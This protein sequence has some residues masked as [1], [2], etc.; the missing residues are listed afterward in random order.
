[1]RV[2][3]LD[4]RRTKT[5]NGNQPSS[6]CRR[7]CFS[8]PLSD[9]RLKFWMADTDSVTLRDAAIRLAGAERLRRDVCRLASDDV[10]FRGFRARMAPVPL[11]DFQNPARVAGFAASAGREQS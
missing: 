4:V 2:R 7:G 11:I 6:E 9:A 1:M 10:E 8:L 5:G 3:G